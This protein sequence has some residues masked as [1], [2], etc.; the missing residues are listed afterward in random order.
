[1]SKILRS[2]CPLTHVN[3]KSNQTNRS[4]FRNPKTHKQ[5]SVIVHFRFLFALIGFECVK[6]ADERA[7]FFFAIVFIGVKLGLRRQRA[8]NRRD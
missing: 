4:Q 2:Q 7:T 6:W 1:M 8:I 3:K 5:K